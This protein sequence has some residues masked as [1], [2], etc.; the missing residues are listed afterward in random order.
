MSTSTF[1]LKSYIPHFVTILAGCT[2]A[3]G[4]SVKADADYTAAIKRYQ[5]NADTNMHEDA[6]KV[7]AAF[8]QIY[9]GIRTISLLPSV[10][11]IDRYGENLTD[12]ARESIIQI[13]NNLRS[14]VTISEVYVVQADIEPE[15]IDSHTG[16][17]ET[18]ILMFDDAVAA[19]ESEKGGDEEKITT[20]AQAEA[21]PEVEIFEYRA[22][23]EQM[24]F[25]KQHYS[26]NTNIKDMEVPFIGSHAV[27]TCD[28]GDYEKTNNNEDRA[29][30]VLSVP[31]F[32][33]NGKLKGTITAVLRN[34]IM[35]NMIP[36]KHF[37]LVNNEYNYTILSK[38]E[39]QQN[40]SLTWVEQKKPD[41]ALIFSGVAEIKTTDPR[42]QWV[43]WAGF[44]DADFLSSGDVE[45]VN[46]LRLFG[47][48]FACV[49]VLVSLGI[50]TVIRR[51]SRLM[52]QN[53]LDLERGIAERSAEIENLVK[54]QEKQR[55]AAAQQRKEALE[56]MANNFEQSVKGVIT[57][58]A[59]AS[60][61]IRGGAEN[62]AHI[63]EDTKQR[64]DKVAKISGTVAN[65]ST[66]VAAAAEELTASISEIS[67]QT[68]KSST[69]AKDAATQAEKTKEAIG[70]LSEQSGKVG[71]IVQVISGI[72]EQINLLALNATIESARAG[73]AGKGFAVVANEV[74][75]LATQV[76]KATEEIS[77]QI[78]QMQ[79]ATQT[80]VDSVM[81]IIGTINNVSASVQAVAVAVEEQSSVTN[82]IAKNIALTANGVQDISNNVVEFQR[83]AVQTGETAQQVVSAA[84]TLATESAM[85]KEKVEEFL[86]TVRNS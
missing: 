31:F 79:G 71:E 34:N 15:H 77:S 73:E 2:I 63:A 59:E 68:N 7:T 84:T 33:E 13:Y 27:L 5:Q 86:R 18:P 11:T 43:L 55:L 1:N 61:Q 35:R 17:F 45:A 9:Q 75:Q 72:A 39:G 54:E 53:K 4:G 30:I 42:S 64:S 21:A 3:W 41:P 36:A 49:F 46:N 25:L 66:Q 24:G 65:T 67:T 48:I 22:L 12:N 8:K 50:I 28:N 40:S 82:E 6:E 10:R 19:H 74:K 14:N 78:G 81:S 20:I 32:D 85:L 26:T 83:G 70:L 80:S 60:S 16:T 29:G 58:V 69:V 76:N 38:E 51:N 62:A 56:Q 44:P 37:A 47:N 23:K 52:Q 57:Q